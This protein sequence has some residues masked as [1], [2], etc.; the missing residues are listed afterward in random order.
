MPRRGQSCGSYFPFLVCWLADASTTL[1]P[2]YTLPMEAL[3][4]MTKICSHEELKVGGVSVSQFQGARGSGHTVGV[5]LCYAR[6]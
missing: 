5:H 3:L 1:F 6:I 2:M 4:R